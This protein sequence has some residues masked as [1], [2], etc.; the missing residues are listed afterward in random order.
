MNQKVSNEKILVVDVHNHLHSYIYEEALSDMD[1]TVTPYRS[2]HVSLEKAFEFAIRNSYTC[3]YLI[4]LDGNINL[5]LIKTLFRIKF[6]SRRIMICSNLFAFHKLNKLSLGTILFLIAL[7]A[8]SRFKVF[9]SDPLLEKRL[10]K[11]FCKDKIIFSP[12]FILDRELVKPENSSLGDIPFPIPRGIPIIGLFGRLNNKK[13]IVQLVSS[14]SSYVLTGS[15]LKF[16]FVIAG[17]YGDLPSSTLESLESLSNSG[18]VHYHPDFL[19]EKLLYNLISASHAI[20]S[21]QNN[22]HGSSG[23]FTRSCAYG[24]PPIVSTASTLGHVTLKHN[25][26]YCIDVK[27]FYTS[28]LRL[29][30]LMQDYSLHAELAANSLNYSR[31]KTEQHFRSI[32]SDT[33]SDL[34]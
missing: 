5:G 33:I 26:G 7:R 6:S 27:N 16:F 10:Y 21:V 12:D 20:W 29:L 14:L 34:A 22:F 1:C 9:V 24:I 8:S 23:I 15:K 18:V 11:S 28:F 31:D 25:L 13:C 4:T 3:L 2:S 19:Q 30:D 17:P 32:L